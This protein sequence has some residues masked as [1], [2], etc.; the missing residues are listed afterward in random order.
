MEQRPRLVQKQLN[1]FTESLTMGMNRYRYITSQ[2]CGHRY[3]RHWDISG[4]GRPTRE[5]VFD[6]FRTV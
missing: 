1:L 3:N 4:S 2:R 6:L 5:E